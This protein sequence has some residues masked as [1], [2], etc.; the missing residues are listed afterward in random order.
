[1]GF[2]SKEGNKSSLSK[3]MFWGQAGVTCMQRSNACKSERSQTHWITV[4]SQPRGNELLLPAHGRAQHSTPFCTGLGVHIS[5]SHESQQRFLSHPSIF[6]PLTQLSP[7]DPSPITNMSCSIYIFANLMMVPILVRS[8]KRNP[9]VR[10]DHHSYCLRRG[11]TFRGGHGLMDKV[12]CIR[13][14][15]FL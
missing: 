11:Q 7:R 9:T 12:V 13:A 5:R 4:K 14:T 6:E 2:T 8:V 1:M 15:E 3:R 10:L